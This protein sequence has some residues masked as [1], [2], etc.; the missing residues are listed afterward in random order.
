[1][2]L[3]DR[4]TKID[5][6]VLTN[7]SNP[8]VAT[9]ID[10]ARL[11][12][13]AVFPDTVGAPIITGFTADSETVSNLGGTIVLTIV[14]SEGS[15]FSINVDTSEINLTGSIP[16][17][18][19]STTVDWVIDASM[20]SNILSHSASI[21]ALGGSVLDENLET[22]IVVQQ[23]AAQANGVSTDF[24]NPDNP[25]QGINQGPGASPFI[26]GYYTVDNPNGLTLQWYGDG[27]G[28]IDTTTVPGKVGFIVTGSSGPGSSGGLEAIG[29]GFT[30]FRQ[31][32]AEWS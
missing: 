15:F 32:W 6:I 31:E 3:F 29:A 8:P 28:V 24:A 19:I 25:G 16:D 27:S 21:S 4:N 1:M 23:D 22:S 13:I 17:G 10:V 12:T 30:T 26:A 5:R 9:E 18:Q 2:P 11:G 14:G 7:D 20:N